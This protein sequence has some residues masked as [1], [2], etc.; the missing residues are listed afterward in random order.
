M[1]KIVFGVI[2]MML[3]VFLLFRNMGYVPWGIS[4]WVFSWQSLLIAIGAILLFDRKPNNKSAGLVLILIGTIFLLS[5]SMYVGNVLVPALVIVAGMILIVRASTGRRLKDT[6]D[7]TKT[8][9]PGNGCITREYVFT[10]S[11]E[12][13]AY[14]KLR[15]VAID[16]VFSGVELDFSQTEWTGAIQEPVYIKVSSVFSGVTL[17]VP[18]DWDIIVRKSSVFGGFVDKRPLNI[19]VDKEKKV[20]LELEAVFGGGEIRCYE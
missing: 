5:K 2:V 4:R 14:G 1:K 6:F 17:Y 10:G 16:A 3:G 18:D 9:I 20:I 19:E 15:N 11:K 8:T 13:W 12:K 7:Q